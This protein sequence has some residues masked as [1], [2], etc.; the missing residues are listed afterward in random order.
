M[1]S[2]SYSSSSKYYSLQLKSFPLYSMEAHATTFN[3]R[4]ESHTH[5]GTPMLTDMPDGITLPMPILNSSF[6][7]AHLT[8]R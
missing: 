5:T 8:N 7:S 1:H 4:Q 6:V 2:A 3:L